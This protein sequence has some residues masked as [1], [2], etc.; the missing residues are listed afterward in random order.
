MSNTWQML[1][2]ER[3]AGHRSRNS[4]CHAN[5][6]APRK[7]ATNCSYAAN[8]SRRLIPPFSWDTR[9][10][11]DA[12]P[13]ADP[14]NFRPSIL[15]IVLSFDHH[16][17]N[18]LH[19]AMPCTSRDYFLMSAILTRETSSTKTIEMGTKGRRLQCLG[20][21]DSEASRAR[22]QHFSDPVRDA[23]PRRS[24]RDKYVADQI[25]VAPPVARFGKAKK[26]SL[27]RR[28]FS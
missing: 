7:P 1:A 19:Q 10:D 9:M 4:E 22:R 24:A 17:A 15:S 11:I 27:G 23:R 18:E 8:A 5:L 20:G 26:I 3:H 21:E 2:P 6:A 16:D 13:R 25:I 14:E 28:T 12:T